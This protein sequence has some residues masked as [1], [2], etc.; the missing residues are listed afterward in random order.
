M[1][2]LA[3]ENIE[4]V[5]TIICLAPVLVM[6]YF[7]RSQLSPKFLFSFPAMHELA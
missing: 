7:S 3:S 5:V 6:N 1:L 4:V 2:P